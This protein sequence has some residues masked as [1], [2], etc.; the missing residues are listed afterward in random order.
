LKNCESAKI[1]VS[2][3]TISP[4]T[5]LIGL[6]MLKPERGTLLSD[7]L[8]VKL[9]DKRY[10]LSASRINLAL[11]VTHLGDGLPFHRPSDRLVPLLAS[12]QQWEALKTATK[13]FLPKFGKK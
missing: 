6:A 12:N 3:V 8:S 9:T 7:R 1:Q 10:F 5:S 2:P 11:S 13:T 4:I